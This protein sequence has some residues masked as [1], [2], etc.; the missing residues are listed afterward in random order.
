[1]T[2]VLIEDHTPTIP[3]RKFTYYDFGPVLSHNAEWNFIVGG[4]GLGKT[5]GAKRRAIKRALERGEE[6][7][8]LRRYEK[9]RTKSR[10]TFFADLIANGEFPGWDFRVVG[11]YFQAARTPSNP[12]DKKQDWKV[13]G[14][15][16][17]LSTAQQDKS[18]AFPNVTTII[19]DEFIIEKGAINYLPNETYL[20]QQLFSTVDRWQDKTTVFFLANAVDLANPYFITYGILPDPDTTFMKLNRGR[21]KGYIVADFPDAEQ[22]RSEV[23]DTRFGMMIDGSEFEEMAVGNKF[24]GS[25]KAML[26]VKDPKALLFFNFKTDTR[27]VAVWVNELQGRYYIHEQVP[28]GQRTVTM[29]P[30]Y[31]GGNVQ[32]ILPR[33]PIMKRL[34]RAFRTYHMQ[35]ENDLL[36]ELWTKEVV[37]KCL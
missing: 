7:I 27:T 24:K 2:T 22:F 8:Y 26:G 28:P 32:L 34:L 6:F 29:N 17:V 13:I 18:V 36:R 31:L 11:N 35:F 23:R 10:D 37:F 15:A 21:A 30:S 25:S 9:E 14:Y 5:Y 4:R 3:R 20:F 16:L 12:E 1:M 33:E 19:F